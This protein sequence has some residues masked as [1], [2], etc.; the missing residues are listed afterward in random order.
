MKRSLG[1]HG[2]R[3]VGRFRHRYIIQQYKSFFAFYE[4]HFRPRVLIAYRIAMSVIFGVKAGILAAC[5]LRPWGDRTE[6]LRRAE[7]FVSIVRL[8]HSRS[9][10][11]R[12]VMRDVSFRYIDP[13]Q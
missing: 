13:P 4:T 12:N 8:M 5:G 9:F 1:P 10:R 3:T 2:S 7:T 11:S 6:R